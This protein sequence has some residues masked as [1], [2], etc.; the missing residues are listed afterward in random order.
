[1]IHFEALDSPSSKTEVDSERLVHSPSI[2]AVTVAAVHDTVSS[3]S[4]SCSTF[5]ELAKFQVLE[6]KHRAS[7]G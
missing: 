5:L 7:L 6:M 4:N 2:A 3:N 1:M